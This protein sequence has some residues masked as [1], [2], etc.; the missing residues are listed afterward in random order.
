MGIFRST[1]PTTWDDVD[2][3]IINESAPAPNIAGV[4]ANIAIMVGQ[5]QRGPTELTEVG[6]IAAFHEQFGKSNY[7]MNMAMKNKK[8]GRLR[9]VRVVAADAALASK[10]FQS[11]ASN[12]LTFSAK[13]GKGAYGNNIQVKIE[14]A[15]S[16]RQEKHTVLC[17]AD[18]ADS[19][20][21]K[22]FVLRDEVGTVGVWIDVDDGGGSAPAGA[23]ACAR[24]IEVTTIETGDSASVVASK[25][26]AV[27]ENDSKFSASADGATITVTTVAYQVGIGTIG[28]GD[29]GF[30][31]TRTQDGVYAGKKYTIHDNNSGA[32]IGDE[33]YDNVKIAEID[34]QTFAGSLLVT[35][36]VNSS[37][38][39]PSN[40]DFTNLENGSDGTVADSDYET[41]LEQASTERAG[42]FLFLDEYNSVRNGYLKQHAADTQDKMVILA[43][44]EVQSVAEVLADAALNRDA[45]GRI[46]YAYPWVQTR[47]DGLNVY[48]SPA[49]WLVALMSQTAPHIDPAFSANTQYLAGVIGLKKS[50]TRADYI[51]LMNGG[52]CS[53]ERDEDIGFKVKSGVVTQI[54]NSEKVMILRRRMADFLTNSVA[55]FLK[56]YQNAVN[57]KA[58]RT[59]IN[60]AIVGFDQGLENAGILPKDSEVSGG[61]AK[62]ID[63][64][65]QNTDLSIGQGFLKILYKRRIYSSARFIVLSAE[66]GTTVVVTEAA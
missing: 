14:E 12:R 41:A 6:S 60:G 5:A 19:L 37:A 64:E 58:N 35:V 23:A 55:L 21:Q 42:N 46:I 56:N 52:V 51:N 57:S 9:L 3:I 54:A 50:L 20:D 26:A 38:A 39:E 36:A 2:G 49:S 28:N 53:F 59:A 4:A 31:V 15:S 7:G 22:Y 29:S 45:D 11:S 61:L 32:V 33:S 62:L 48:T 43:G 17:V 27:L 30:T 47:I 18:V 25:I 34:S 24:Q 65:S 66:I 1:D 63:T 10:A 13:Q 16:S 44:P 40:C 8:F